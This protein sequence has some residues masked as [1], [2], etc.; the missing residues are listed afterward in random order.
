QDSPLTQVL[1]FV[2]DAGGELIPVHARTAP[3][4]LGHGEQ[5]REELVEQVL[6]V[7][8]ELGPYRSLETTE[9]GGVRRRQ[10]DDVARRD[11]PEHP[12]GLD[13][14]V[15]CDAVEVEGGAVGIYPGMA[16]TRGGGDAGVGTPGAGP[17]PA[18]G[19]AAQTLVPVGQS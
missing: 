13:L 3:G 15:R 7:E 18:R 16:A 1:D 2:L 5:A 6:A 9:V 12:W 4:P 17:L 11:G 19:R 8:D 10:L 14:R